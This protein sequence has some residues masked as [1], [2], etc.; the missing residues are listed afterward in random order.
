[1]PYQADLH[2]DRALTRI[3]VM[4]RNEAYVA[5]QVLPVVEVDNRSDLYFIYRKDDFL[6]RSQIE[7]T[8]SAAHLTSAI[9]PGGVARELDYSL[10]TGSYVAE[11]YG[12]RFL[13]TDAAV[14]RADNP[15]R[16]DRDATIR[17]TEQLKID[18][19]YVTAQLALTSTGYPTANKVLLTTGGTGTSWKQYTSTSSHPFTDIV[20]GKK[21]VTTSIIREPNSI[22]LNYNTAQTLSEH[23]DYKELYKYVDP[24]G[25]TRSG[26]VKNLR[27]LN[28]IEGMNQ[29]NGA[30]EGAAYNGS[31]I[32]VDENGTDIALIFYSE[33]N[34]SLQSV[35][36]GYTMD[37]ADETTGVRGY[38]FLRYR[39]DARHGSWI[40]GSFTRDWVFI[41]QDSN[42]LAIGGYLIS[43]T[44][45]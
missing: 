3:S 14:A 23:P 6:R 27:G 15:L 36:M 24:N 11:R 21:A 44:T 42:N 17:V 35:S 37:A 45:L 8:G 30:V 41:A 1:M 34:P 18:N 25:L 32:W 13:V 9:R 31:Q 20:N 5:E 43:G 38:A 16:P 10:S 12:Y 29:A 19:E 28:V 4:Y 7:G 39:D 26:V 40:E 22:L 33:P 2:I